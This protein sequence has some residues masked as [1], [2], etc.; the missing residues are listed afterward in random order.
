MRCTSL[1]Y[2]LLKLRKKINWNLISFCW[3]ESEIY[4]FDTT[5]KTK[6]W[7][8]NTLVFSDWFSLFIYEWISNWIFWKQF[9]Q[10]VFFLQH[11][12]V[13]SIS[14]IFLCIC[15]QTFILSRLQLILGIEQFF[16]SV[17][18][19]YFFHFLYNF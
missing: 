2:L 1:A 11:V 12:N 16:W 6:I 15:F 17:L 9:K 4:T 5:Y 13:F 10:I 18:N 14:N 7:N 19:S 8:I 3:G